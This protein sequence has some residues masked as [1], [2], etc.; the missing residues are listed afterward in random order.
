LTV[1][2]STS[3][4]FRVLVMPAESADNRFLCSG[5][6]LRGCSS[7]S[8]FFRLEDDD[9]GSVVFRAKR[10][11]RDCCGLGSRADGETGRAAFLDGDRDVDGLL[12]GCGGSGFVVGDELCGDSK[13][14]TS[15]SSSSTELCFLDDFLEKNFIEVDSGQPKIPSSLA[16]R[17]LYMRLAGNVKF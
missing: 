13:T 3:I 11:G 17:L 4:E 7:G 1:S 9:P 12:G 14:S 16:S 15:S 8:I 5:G 10:E 2:L 6:R